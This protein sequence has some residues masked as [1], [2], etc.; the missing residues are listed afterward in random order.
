MS[1]PAVYDDCEAMIKWLFYVCFICKKYNQV[2]LKML[3][4]VFSYEF[5]LLNLISD[6]PC[7]FTL[8]DSITTLF[9]W[10]DARLLMW[11]WNVLFNHIQTWYVFFLTCLWPVTF[12]LTLFRTCIMC[13]G[14]P[15][16]GGGCFQTYNFWYYEADLWCSSGKGW[17]RL[18]Y[19]FLVY[20]KMRCSMCYFIFITTIYWSSLY[21]S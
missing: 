8:N 13:S 10:S 20:E 2:L 11:H 4:K 9:A 21:L 5:E 3:P 17:K 1:I 16:R 18:V 7:V 19:I 12:F 6:P 15:R 14:Y